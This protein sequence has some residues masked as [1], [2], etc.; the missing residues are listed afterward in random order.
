MLSEFHFDDFIGIEITHQKQ[1]YL[2]GGNLSLRA[3]STVP[4]QD[5][6]KP[7][8]ERQRKIFWSREYHGATNDIVH[9]ARNIIMQTWWDWQKEN[10]GIGIP[11]DDTSYVHPENLHPWERKALVYINPYA[12]YK[13]SGEY[14]N[15]VESVLR[16][17][18]FVMDT[19]TTFRKNQ[20]FEEMA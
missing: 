17:N 3:V 20:V 5:C 10:H 19:V 14:F 18:G 6:C 16:A 4:E 2:E 12:G 13:K 15:K 8:N 11:E 1:G 7:V 9:R